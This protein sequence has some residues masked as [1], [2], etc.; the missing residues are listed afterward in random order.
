MR[1]SLRRDRDK[2]NG[3]KL[4]SAIIETMEQ[5]IMLTTFMV[6]TTGDGGVPGDGSLRSAINASNLD[7]GPQTNLIEF[8]IGTGPEYDLAS[9]LAVSQSV[10][11]DGESQPGYAGTRS[12]TSTAP[13]PAPAPSD[14]TSQAAI[15]PLKA[16]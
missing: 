12:S 3:Y 1:R 13:A 2:S 4:N 7:T 9:G 10:T 14:W 11:I 5:R 6:T 8:A 15:L 16:W